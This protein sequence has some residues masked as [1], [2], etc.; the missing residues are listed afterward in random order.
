ML[1]IFLAPLIILELTA[2]P[3]SA[4]SDK[5][6]GFITAIVIKSSKPASRSFSAV[7]GPTPGNSSIVCSFRS[8][9][10][11]TSSSCSSTSSSTFF[12]AILIPLLY[13]LN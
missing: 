5:S 2:S 13:P 3:N 12:F 11:T 9:T 6:A 1:A 10:L 4:C 7:A 8:P